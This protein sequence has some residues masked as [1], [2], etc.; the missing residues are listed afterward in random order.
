MNEKLVKIELTEDQKQRLIQSIDETN[1]FIE[2]EEKH[3]SEF[4]KIDYLNSL[5]SHLEKLNRMLS[6]GLWPEI[7][8][9]Q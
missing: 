9:K 6:E 4:R 2:K 8:R 5:Y 3:A 7:W 1:R